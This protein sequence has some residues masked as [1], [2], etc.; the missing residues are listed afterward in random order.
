MRG[1]H[2]R[3]SHK[4]QVVRTTNYFRSKHIKGRLSAIPYRSSLVCTP[5][6]ENKSIYMCWPDNQLFLSAEDI[7]RVQQ[8]RIGCA[9][10]RTLPDWHESRQ[11][12]RAISHASDTRWMCSACATRPPRHVGSEVCPVP[13]H[14]DRPRLILDRA[15][16]LARDSCCRARAAWSRVRARLAQGQRHAPV[17]TTSNL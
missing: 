4:W 13:S 9:G 7:G 16:T 17:V 5:L 8:K 14:G 12:C 6:S 10:R 1:S 3:G 11:L 2:M 15:I